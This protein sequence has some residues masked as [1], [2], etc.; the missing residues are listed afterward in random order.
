MRE[1]EGATTSLHDPVDPPSQELVSLEDKI[2]LEKELQQDD[3]FLYIPDAAQRAA[4]ANGR[5]SRH[6][7]TSSN[8]IEEG[9]T[10]E[11]AAIIKQCKEWH[12]G[13]NV[14]VG[15]SWGDL[16]YNLQD[17]WLQNGCDRHVDKTTEMV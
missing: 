9:T 3:D 11:A 4:A 7:R 17:L 8:N 10:K 1:M 5:R 12:K 15:V 16:P 14:V 6:K 13:Y 2:K